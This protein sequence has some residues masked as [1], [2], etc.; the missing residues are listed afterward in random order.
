MDVEKIHIQTLTTFLK[1]RRRAKIRDVIDLCKRN[2]NAINLP[3]DLNNPFKIIHHFWMLHGDMPPPDYHSPPEWEWLDSVYNIFKCSFT[4][5]EVKP[6]L[7]KKMFCII[8]WEWVSTLPRLHMA[9]LCY[10]IF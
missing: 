9:Q 10:E 7:V 2:L 1:Q 8:L 3:F 5:A 4:D 6:E